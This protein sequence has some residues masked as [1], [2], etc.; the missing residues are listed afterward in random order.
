MRESRVADIAPPDP[1][2]SAAAPVHPAGQA[3][4]RR[5]YRFGW[6][7]GPAVPRPVQR[8]VSRAGA[9]VAVNRGGWHLDRLRENLHTATGSVVSDDLMRRSVASYLRNLTEM[10]ALPGW[11]DAEIVSRVTTTGEEHLR[12]AYADAGAVVALPHTGNW[13]LAGAWACRTG[14]PVA[15]VAEQLDEPDFTA[16]RTFRESLGMTILSHRDPAALSALIGA[17]R[18]G[19]LVCL[20]ADRDLLGS[21]LPV[22]WRGHP[23]TLPAGPAVV[24]RRTGA[25][26]LPTVC[27]F[28]PN[29]IRLDISAPVDPRPGRD[30]LISMTQDVADVFADRIAAHPQDWHLMQPFFPTES[31]RR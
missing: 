5:L 19:R 26:L 29:G 10:F 1:R 8:A 7:V 15:T 18:A 25:A 30:G 17:V 11:T 16:F 22:R 24:A 2:R 28:T 9:R 12:R 6:R 31:G 4:L 14:M 13:D 27:T 3:A 23:V 20:I 21:G